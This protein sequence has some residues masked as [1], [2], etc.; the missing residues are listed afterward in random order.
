MCDNCYAKL[1]KNVPAL[2]LEKACDLCESGDD[3]AAEFIVKET[4]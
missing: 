3:E 2:I 4:E 1:T